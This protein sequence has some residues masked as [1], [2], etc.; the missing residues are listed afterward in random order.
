VNIEVAGH[1][2]TL[3][4]DQQDRPQ[5]NKRARELLKSTL[6]NSHA[7]TVVERERILEIIREINFGQS[8]YADP[9]SAPD[10][11]Q[12]LAVQYLIEGSLGMNEDKTLKDTLEKERTY[13]DG[14]DYD[15]GIWENV[16][17]PG[18][19]NREKMAVAIRKAQFKQMQKR[20]QRA[21]FSIARYLS[22]Y[23]VRTG[24]VVTTVMGLGTNGLEA[25][26]DAVDELVTSLSDL[27]SDIH[28][29]AVSGDR[30]YLDAGSGRGLAEGNALQ[31]LH[32]NAPIRDNAGQI[33]GY[34]ETEVGEIQVT[35][36]RPLLT[37]A[38]VVR[39][40]T[41]I[42]RDDLVKPAKH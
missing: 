27:K 42:A 22:V 24:E 12:L 7:F 17:N 26:Q 21:W 23:E 16:F 1:E 32:Q 29:A 31:V 13:K 38:K 40:S 18:K 5:M 10:Q 14:V 41:Q 30:I 37:V 36:I 20:Y 9:S 33:I 34:D 39:Q 11:G 19:S 35:E 6:L 28:V 8:R 3:S 2:A 15:P 25:I 4:K